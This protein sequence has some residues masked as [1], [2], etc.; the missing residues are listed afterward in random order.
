MHDYQAGNVEIEDWHRQKSEYA[1]IA[2]KSM[3]HIKSSQG[4]AVID[5][6]ESIIYKQRSVK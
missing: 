2:R 1:L 5:V 6:C 3:C 4:I